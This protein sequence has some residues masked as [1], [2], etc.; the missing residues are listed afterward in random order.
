MATDRFARSAASAI[1]SITLLAGPALAQTPPHAPGSPAAANHDAPD[2]S[3]NVTYLQVDLERFVRDAQLT[4]GTLTDGVWTLTAPP[5]RGLV[6]LPV[7]LGPVTAD[8]D[9]SPG[10]VGITGGQFVAWLIPP[11]LAAPN[12][13]PQHP[14]KIENAPAPLPGIVPRLSR[15][16]RL[17]ADG[18][19]HWK[20]ARALPEGKV[21]AGQAYAELIDRTRIPRPEPAPRVRRNPGESAA[22]YTKR[23]EQAFEEYHRQIA[24]YTALNRALRDLPT[25]F[26]QP[27]PPMIYA[28]F[29]LPVALPG[30]VVTGPAPLPWRINSEDFQKLRQLAA[31]HG[32]PAALRTTLGPM[33]S[34]GDLASTR[35]AA[36]VLAANINV[37]LREDTELLALTTRLITHEDPRV[38]RPIL[39]ALATHPDVTVGP[40]LLE[41]AAS[42]PDPALALLAVCALANRQ[43][44]AN[45]VD[46]PETLK[47]SAAVVAAALPRLLATPP[48][49][50]GPT[51]AQILTPAFLMS[52]KNPA[53]VPVLAAT[54]FA[55]ATPARRPEV[56]A[57]VLEFARRGDPLAAAWL[58]TALLGSH[59]PALVKL[60]LQ[61]IAGERDQG[62]ERPRDQGRKDQDTQGIL[63]ATIDR[64]APESLD[65]CSSS[66]PSI[67]GSLGPL[68]PSCQF[69]PPSL[70]QPR[71][72]VPRP[73]QVPGVTGGYRRTAPQ[74]QPR[75][76]GATPPPSMS[77]AVTIPEMQP[78]APDGKHST[79]EVS[80]LAP[81]APPTA[82]PGPLVIASPEHHLIALLGSSDGGVRRLAW[83]AL[84]H[85]TLARAAGDG[86]Q[87]AAVA[88][89]IAD[90]AVGTPGD[91][92]AE[93][94][95]FFVDLT[96][97]KLR[98]A[99]LVKV[100]AAGRGEGQTAA[101][102]ALVQSGA[103]PLASAM[104]ALPPDQRQN[105]AKLWYAGAAP[106]RRDRVP[107]SWLAVGA[108]RQPETGTTPSP[109]V[110][111]FAQQMAAGRRPMAVEWANAM[112]NDAMLA[113][114]LGGDV[115]YAGGC[116]AA[117]IAR[118]LPPDPVSV[119]KLRDDA[120]KIAVSV[121]DPAER[122]KQTAR[123][124]KQV[125]DDA[126]KARLVAVSGPYRVHATLTAPAGGKTMHDAGEVTLTFTGTT[127][128]MTPVSV[129]PKL[130]QTPLRLLLASPWE[131]AKIGGEAAKLNWPRTPVELT[132]DDHGDWV[133][134]AI[135][136]D[137]G[138][139]DLRW[140]KR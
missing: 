22:Q 77:G 113:G 75:R 47:H 16:V 58:D 96:D 129:G 44:A 31:G 63:S 14:I 97:V 109:I 45:P 94:S 19:V 40:I 74:P 50:I 121:K 36:T 26:Q 41:K 134:G 43:V 110:R 39:L 72:V 71:P 59:D 89:R 64:W 101:M 42:D 6:A 51:A 32:E 106:V 107:A 57:T 105:I 83:A 92:P 132:L 17:T 12:T 65:P 4:G 2:P 29:S 88:Q 20:L 11:S 7:T 140:V 37:V 60:T 99:G 62:T 15:E 102:L 108:M 49:K 27:A 80:L 8:T 30:F 111:W 125:T 76:R 18:A 103:D 56:I 54:D 10:V 33:V 85:F 112:G 136:P 122:L 46:P 124:W 13:P 3:Q 98:T 93:A 28:V 34:A 68:V 130:E 78:A 61:K 131:L 23:R 52:H 100:L 55:A 53:L 38:R 139:M 69:A 86:A 126:V 25:E 67:P 138:R 24:A 114:L 81:L 84:D 87:T 48:K 1:L 5:G 120:A 117:L 95:R 116:A 104:A 66:D 115:E 9:L 79:D 91:T 90:A 119:A 133:G 123:A 128:T 82:P 70:P 127:A 135:T 137:G 73:P 118:A 21:A 35:I